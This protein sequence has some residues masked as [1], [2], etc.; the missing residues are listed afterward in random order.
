MRILIAGGGTGGHLFPGI[1]LAEELKRRNPESVSIFV[2]TKTGIESRVIPKLGFELRNIKIGGLKGKSSMEKV[3]NLS[4]IPGSVYQSI[5]LI[6]EYKPKLV[7]GMG[8]YASA[9]VALAAKLMRVKTAICEQNTIPGLTNRILAG[10]VDRIFTSFPETMY[11]SSTKRT[12]FTGNPVRRDLIAGSSK[13]KV[14][15]G[16]FSLLI[17]GGSQGAHSINE[18]MLNALDYLESVKDSLRIVHQTGNT[19]YDR[20]CRVYRKKGFDSEVTS[21][22]DDM[23]SVYRD[24]DLVVCRAG[25]TTIS[26]LTVYGRASL[27]VPYPFAANNHQEVNARVLSD[28]GAARMILNGDLKGDNLAEMIMGLAADPE[29][30]SRMG[31]EASKLGRRRAAE[32][33]VDSCYELLG[34]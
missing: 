1:A 16:E 21:F 17:L 2:G 10:F 4:I 33:I 27:L 30:L 29:T 20:T 34:M 18:H 25:A 7:I 13:D 26:E 3:R 23:A 19:D 31:K 12:R 11:L 8:G 9:P 14:Y 15:R 6:R 28:R 32:D 22:I 24:A 5:R